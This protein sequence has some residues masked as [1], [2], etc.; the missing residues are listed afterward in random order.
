MSKITQVGGAAGLDPR[1]RSLLPLK[2]LHIYPEKWKP[3]R[4]RG[5][6][7]CRDARAHLNLYSMCDWGPRENPIY[8]LLY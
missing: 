3:G 2:E 6:G 5:V 8:V 7:D 4:Y 1:S